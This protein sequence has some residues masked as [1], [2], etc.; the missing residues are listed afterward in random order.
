MGKSR[1]AQG[2]HKVVFFSD[3]TDWA[4]S[5]PSSSICVRITRLAPFPSLC[6][7]CNGGSEKISS[8]SCY[9]SLPNNGEL[10][11][12]SAN[13]YDLFENTIKFSPEE[14]KECY[15]LWLF[16]LCLAVKSWGHRLQGTVF[17]L[18]LFAAD[19]CSGDATTA[20]GGNS[21][22]ASGTK[23]FIGDI[24]PM[25]GTSPTC[26]NML[27]LVRSRYSRATTHLVKL[28]GEVDPLFQL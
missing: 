5:P 12:E 23:G 9:R 4:N 28:V 17:V 20:L 13:V 10:F 14:K 26:K 22:P 19:I 15:G 7:S 11:S 21:V 8:G 6:I 24:N 3:G 27:R 2:N 16:K 1:E 18:C 25:P